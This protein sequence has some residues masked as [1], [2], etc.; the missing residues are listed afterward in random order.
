MSKK[1]ENEEKMKQEE[2]KEAPLE[3]EETQETPVEEVVEEVIETDP[4]ADLQ[5]QVEELNKELAA[6]KND[7]ARAYADTDNTRKR[8][9]RDADLAKK[10]RFQQAALELLPILDNMTMALAAKPE[11]EE[12]ANFVKGFEMI[13][14]QLENAL[15]NEGVKEIEAL[16]RP[17]D[18]NT[19]QALMTEAKEGVEP[20]IVLEVLQKGYMLKDRLLRPA[21]VKVSE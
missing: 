6:A 2:V 17:F 1:K 18:A 5:K 4:I 10:Y 16:N 9:L 7:V 11:G 21:L 8:L 14:S 15:S 3:T 13:R 12:A 19:M 20:G